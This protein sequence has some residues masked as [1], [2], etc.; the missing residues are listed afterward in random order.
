MSGGE[1]GGVRIVANRGTC[2]EER[3]EEFILLLLVANV[4]FFLGCFPPFVA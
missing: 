4:H 1:I 3:L 2:H